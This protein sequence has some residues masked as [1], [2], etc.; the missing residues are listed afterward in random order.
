MPLL[1][2]TSAPQKTEARW[3]EFHS[4]YQPQRPA[5][6][7]P[8]AKVQRCATR[9]PCIPFSLL[10]GQ[11]TAAIGR[12]GSFERHRS[13]IRVLMFHSVRMNINQAATYNHLRAPV[14]TMKPPNLR[15]GHTVCTATPLFSGSVQGHR[16]AEQI[17]LIHRW[18]AG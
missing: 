13:E 12:S 15:E 10:A 2:D 9:A 14:E 16:V 5:R 7:P 8:Q 3:F 18:T 11:N 4:A 1:F 6:M 17:T